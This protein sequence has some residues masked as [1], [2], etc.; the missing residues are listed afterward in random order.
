MHT[1]EVRNDYQLL[2]VEEW[3]LEELVAWL[4]DEG[5]YSCGIETGC[6]P[7]ELR[8]E[9]LLQADAMGITLRRAGEEV[10]N[11]QD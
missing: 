6:V 2:P 3:S 5:A 7:E 1:L 10:A 11:A 4:I 8:A 9:V